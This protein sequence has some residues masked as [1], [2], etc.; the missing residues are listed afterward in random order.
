M[1][2]S[3]VP[4]WCH[5]WL[6]KNFPRRDGRRWRR[7]HCRGRIRLLF[8]WFLQHGNSVQKTIVIQFPQLLLHQMLHPGY[9]VHENEF[10]IIRIHDG[11]DNNSRIRKHSSRKTLSKGGKQFLKCA[12]LINLKCNNRINQ[13]MNR[14]QQAKTVMMPRQINQSIMCWSCIQCFRLKIIILEPLIYTSKREW[15]PLC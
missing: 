8:L 10:K 6:H 5:C 12:A 9:S 3:P 13:S 15:P 2:C 4:V 11:Y 1:E 7:F 14:I